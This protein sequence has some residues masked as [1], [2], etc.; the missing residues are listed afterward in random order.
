M[1]AEPIKIGRIVRPAILEVTLFLLGML[2]VRR[3]IW[4]LHASTF[5]IVYWQ[6]G[7][8]IPLI[9]L[10][11]AMTGAFS[12]RTRNVE[13]APAYK[14][15]LRWGTPVFFFLYVGC[16]ALSERL[17]IG[18]FPTAINEYV[19]NLGVV[20]VIAGLY[21][22][23]WAYR[24]RPIQLIAEN[25]EEA[26]LAKPADEAVL[27]AAPAIEV[28]AADREAA[29]LAADAKNFSEIV[30]SGPHKLLRHPDAAGKLL[31]LCGIPLVFN[32]WL[33]LLAL[34]GIIILLKW[35]ISDQE[36]FRISQLGEPYLD[37]RKRT[38]NLIPY[39]Y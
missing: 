35:Y 15:M 19:R 6:Q 39:L 12:S 30:P 14:G 38:W 20:I 9:A 31:A 5:A 27:T 37:Y 22:R 3:E 10:D 1:G 29:E 34:P 18:V 33:P 4:Q 28:S 7:L 36:A 17:A 8:L 25:T 24:T 13:N 23:L 32:S 2:F 16:A 26:N 21:L 11:G